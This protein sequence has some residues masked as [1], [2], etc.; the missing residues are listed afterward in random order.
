[1]HCDDVSVHVEH[2]LERHEGSAFLELGRIELEGDLDGSLR[3]FRSE[4]GGG[5]HGVAIGV[6]EGKT[7]LLVHDGAVGG[8]GLACDEPPV[9]DGI[10]D[11][12]RPALDH[13]VAIGCVDECG[14]DLDDRD[15][16]PF[17]LDVLV[18]REDGSFGIEQLLEHHQ[19]VPA[20]VGRVEGELDYLGAFGGL[21]CEP[22][23]RGHIGG[24]KPLAASQRLARLGVHERRLERVGLA[25]GQSLEGNLVC[26][27]HLGARHELVAVRGVGRRGADVDKVQRL[28]LVLDVGMNCHLDAVL[29]QALESH[30][31]LAREQAR[32]EGELDVDRAVR[33]VGREL[34]G[35]GHGVALRVEQGLAG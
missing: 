16:L 22:D 15:G 27:Y 17:I 4:L 10:H 33:V 13:V 1:M 8:V 12:D 19:S 6:L 21:R 5:G 14:P 2:L 9:L 34:L 18:H 31:I 20:E 23:G 28:P 30:D 32:V 24:E 26:D 29:D 7:C 11:G 3:A 35:G 25:R